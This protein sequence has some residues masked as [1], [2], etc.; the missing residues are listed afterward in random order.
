MKTVLCEPQLG[1]KGVVRYNKMSTKETDFIV[2]S[3]MNF[4]AYCDGVE[5]SLEIAEKMIT[6][7]WELEQI[8]SN[9]KSENL[10]EVC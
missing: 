8:I 1:K 5:S 7:L 9:L 2:K 3:M 6:P 10:L 4:L